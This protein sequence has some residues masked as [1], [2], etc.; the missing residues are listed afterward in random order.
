MGLTGQNS[1][2]DDMVCA[3][4]WDAINEISLGNPPPRQLGLPNGLCTGMGCNQWN[5]WGFPM[6]CA[7]GWDAIN[8]ISLGTPPPGNWVF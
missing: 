5:Q 7:R 3:R 4:G 8:G 1:S 2:Y 6:V